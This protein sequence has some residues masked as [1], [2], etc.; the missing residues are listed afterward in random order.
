[1]L[2]SF[3]IGLREG[4]EAAL[5]VAI[6]AAFLRAN[7]SLDLLRW[8]WFGVGAAVTVCLGVGIALRVASQNLPSR[9]QERLETII[10]AVAVG[11]VTYM[12]V[13]MRRHAAGIKTQLEGAVGS[14]LD[15]GTAW[16]LVTMAFLAVM[17]E[18]F[19]TAVFLVAAF[20][21]SD[22]PRASASGALVGILA[23]CLLGYAIY[24]GGL[25]INLARFFRVTG[26]VL[27]VV[28]AGLV[29][30][31]LHSAHEAGWI[32]AGQQHVLDLRWLV[33]PGSVRSSLLTGVLGLQPRLVVVELAGWLVFVVPMVVFVLWPAGRPVP[34]RA[35]VI[36]GA[37]TAVTA[38]VAVVAL[39]IA[40]PSSRAI[41]SAALPTSAGELDVTTVERAADHATFRLDGAAVG[42]ALV[43]T[44]MP[45]AAHEHG[46]RNAVRYVADSV[47]TPIGG[48][49]KR[50]LSEVAQLNG[51]RL[52]LGVS[53]ETDPGDVSVSRSISREVA[54]WVDARTGDV[55]D[56][57]VVESVRTVADLSVGRLPLGLPEET[58]VA[59]TDGT[60]TARGRA[61]ADHSSQLE[62]ADDLHAW[63]R[64]AAFVG[65]VAA[66]AGAVAVWSVDRRRRTDDSRTAGR[67]PPT[68]RGSALPVV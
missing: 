21:E 60:V 7:G 54:V 31:A 61:A 25:R 2:P 50:S 14:A 46:G 48:A 4:L 56:A 32:D 3:V 22:N 58:V 20:N 65:I 53:P 26:V 10:A 34:R 23:A 18:G 37:A 5:I 44:A 12:V 52:P 28:A 40:A 33:D 24:R 42:E 41:A 67:G 1:M 9:Q 17:R 43:V 11:M 59:T 55:L 45:T 30:A 19:E 57:E 15:A 51:G 13:W 8:V 27:V 66:A 35:V 36:G 38:G 16:A 29:V 39:T 6:I 49:E 62:L 64:L 63:Q 68:S 47:D